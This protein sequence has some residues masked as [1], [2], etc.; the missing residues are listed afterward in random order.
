MDVGTDQWYEAKQSIDSVTSSITECDKNIVDYK[1]N[2]TEL[3]NIIHEKLYTELQKV[4]N[5][6]DFFANLVSSTDSTDDKT[7]T[8]TSNGLLTLADYMVGYNE[9]F[10]EAEKTKALL[11]NLQANKSAG[12]YSFMDVEGNQRDYQSPEQFQEAIDKLYSDWR[13]QISSTNDYEQKAIDLIKKKYEAE[14]AYLQE[15]INS[16]KE[17]L[18]AEKD[19]Y[20]YQRSIADKSKNIATLQK[21]ITALSGDDS[22]EGKAR[23]QKLQTSL[24]EAQ[25]DMKDTQYDKMI[26][27]QSD[28]L[29]KL[30]DEYEDLMNKLLKDTN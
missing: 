7:G 6:M 23:V 4:T 13:D 29:D 17:A 18:Q 21:Q 30:Y 28:M 5:E 20:D 8:L 26:S 24:E 3:A 2:I 9:K 14:L 12:N 11:D 27:D 10:F 1:N 16:K 15:L 25:Q 22:E 19:L